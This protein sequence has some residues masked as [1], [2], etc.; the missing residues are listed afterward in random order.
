M[1]PPWVAKNGAVDFKGRDD[2]FKNPWRRISGGFS[3]DKY[4]TL[5]TKILLDIEQIATLT[6]GAIELEPLHLE[7]KHRANANHWIRIQ[8]HARRLFEILSS[9][10]SCTY[11]CQHPHRANLRLDVRNG[12]EIDNSSIRFSF[13]F[14]FDVNTTV[15]TPLPWNWR[16]IKIEPLQTPKKTTRFA[17]TRSIVCMS[18]SSLCPSSY[19]KPPQSTGRIDDLCKILGGKI[20]K[21][22]CLG[23]LDDQ[24]WQHHIYSAR[25]SLE[26]ETRES[27]SLQEILYRGNTGSLAIKQK[28]AIAL[29][30]ASAVSQLH[31]TPWLSESWGMKGI[32]FINDRKG[33]SLFDQP[34]VSKSFAP[35]P[36][37]QQSTK[38]KSR[39]FIKNEMVFALGVEL[40]YGK[41]LLSFKTADDLDAQGNETSFTEFSIAN[42]LTDDI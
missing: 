32:Y 27:A 23:F 29:T 35:V 21:T 6:K 26:N 38:P 13:V 16:D 9:R 20:Q 17:G 31:N 39:C 7:R 30:L 34:Y 42:R 5:L 3:S 15:A 11:P 2:F 36:N 18:S 22:C 14:T 28:C 19:R 4:S 37:S 33:T 8:D 1:R 25:P 24:P 40:S 41:P 10:W 12:C